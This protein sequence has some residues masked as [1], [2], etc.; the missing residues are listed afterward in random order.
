MMMMKIK[1][2]PR[3]FFDDQNDEAD[4]DADV[5]GGVEEDAGDDKT[6][7][8]KVLVMRKKMVIVATGVGGDVR[9]DDTGDGQCEDEDPD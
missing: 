6:M 7:A 5:T 3:T 2:L 8:V 1:M 9:E 4:G